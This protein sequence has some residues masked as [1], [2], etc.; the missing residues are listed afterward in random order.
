MHAARHI[1]MTAALILTTPA[2]VARPCQPCNNTPKAGEKTNCKYREMTFLG[3]AFKPAS[4]ELR[5][6]LGIQ[7]CVGLI[8]IHVAAKSPAEKAGI[9]GGDVLIKFDDQILMT[10]DQLCNLVRMRKSNDVVKISLI[11]K[12]KKKT[13]KARL[14][15]HRRM[16]RPRR[17]GHQQLP[18]DK[19]IPDQM[20]LIASRP[21]A[22]ISSEGFR[23]IN[24][25]F[26][27]PKLSSKQKTKQ[28]N[29]IIK[30]L[31]LPLTAV[32]DG[33]SLSIKGNNAKFV[34]QGTPAF[35][36]A[37]RSLPAATRRQ[38]EQRLKE[39]GKD[40]AHTIHVIQT[41]KGPVFITTML[42]DQAK[43]KEKKPNST[44]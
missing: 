7:N 9:V 5:K 41:S 4:A 40:G 3:V 42:R 15:L 30:E 22:G 23:K 27:N 2:L 16:I 13:V 19:N 32:V 31:S 35:E 14:G 28:I 17:H 8:V 10:P 33:K 44:K 12:G 1:L 20:K 11:R 21:G 26:R 36:E 38:I 43:K 24:T 18:A 37:L 25:I 6:H 34:K 39:S 29:K